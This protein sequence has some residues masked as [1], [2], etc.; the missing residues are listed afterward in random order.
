MQIFLFANR[1]SQIINRI[2]KEAPPVFS[3]V[4]GEKNEREKYQEVQST[5]IFVEYD[6]KAKAGAG[7]RN[8]ESKKLNQKQI[9]SQLNPIRVNSCNSWTKNN[10]C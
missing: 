3:S 5:D 7:H 10:P 8:I 6:A 9:N 2:S 1:I 4:D